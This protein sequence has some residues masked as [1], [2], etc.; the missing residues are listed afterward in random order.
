[1]NAASA[2]CQLSNSFAPVSLRLP[3]LFVLLCLVLFFGFFCRKLSRRGQFLLLHPRKFLRVSFLVRMRYCPSFLVGLP[4]SRGTF[5]DYFQ[6]RSL[7]V[8]SLSREVVRLCRLKGKSA[9]AQRFCFFF[10]VRFVRFH[11]RFGPDEKEKLRSA[12]FPNVPTVSELPLP[13]CGDWMR[14]LVFVSDQTENSSYF[15]FFLLSKFTL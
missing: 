12:L 1:M 8:F 13:L 11:V 7:Q 3:L 15:S 5:S 10:S 6:A 2:R 14:D 9:A 4:L